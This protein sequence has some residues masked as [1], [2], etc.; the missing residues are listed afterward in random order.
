MP[1]DLDEPW[2][3]F[4]DDRHGVCGVLDHLTQSSWAQKEQG[5]GL[6]D[7]DNPT[8]SMTPGRLN[9]TIP[10]VAPSEDA[11]ASSR[12]AADDGGEEMC[13]LQLSHSN[14]REQVPCLLFKVAI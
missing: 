14:V 7:N 11:A 10:T 13:D 1:Q 8:P 4:I 2:R 9:A 6:G 12:R 5:S 3:H